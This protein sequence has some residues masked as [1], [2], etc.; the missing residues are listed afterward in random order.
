MD[1]S[2]FFVY[3][4]LQLINVPAHKS[5]VMKYI[6]SAG[7]A[8]THYLFLTRRCELFSALLFLKKK[9]MADE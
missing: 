8:P 7:T 3:I 9:D 5:S 2:W 6:L 1:I 4:H